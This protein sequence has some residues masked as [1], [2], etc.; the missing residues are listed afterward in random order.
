MKDAGLPLIVTNSYESNLLQLAAA[1]LRVPVIERYDCR[2]VFLAI[3][4]IF[5]GNLGNLGK[6]YPLVSR[7]L[8][9]GH[10]ADG[11]AR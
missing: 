8:R 1:D 9:H 11:R 10:C 6:Q 3:S 5:A 7:S 4:G 2:H